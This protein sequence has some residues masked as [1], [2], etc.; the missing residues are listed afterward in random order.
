MWGTV[1]KFLAWSVIEFITNNPDFL[2]SNQPKIFALGKVLSDQRIH[3]LNP[4]SLICAVRI[5]KEPVGLQRFGHAPVLGELLAVVACNGVDAVF[6][7][8]KPRAQNCCHGVRS[9]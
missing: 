4:C 7:R 3:V 1:A 2:A 5:G 8:S 9:P 6:V